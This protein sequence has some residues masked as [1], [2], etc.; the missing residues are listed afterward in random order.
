MDLLKE[1]I[2]VVIDNYRRRF[3]VPLD[4][5]MSDLDVET[6]SRLIAALELA[7]QRNMPLFDYELQQF[8]ISRP[9]RL[10]LWLKRGIA[11]LAGRRTLML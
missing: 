8:Q 4:I 11:R 5:P 1:P 7:L 9:R 3:N 2:R 6:R 10:W